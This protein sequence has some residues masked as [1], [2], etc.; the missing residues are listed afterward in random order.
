MKYLF[1]IRN[2]KTVKELLKGI[3]IT[4]ILAMLLLLVV[5]V[6]VC[7]ED[8]PKANAQVVLDE[9]NY[10]LIIKFLQ[11][12]FTTQ[13]GQSVDN[14]CSLV[15]IDRSDFPDTPIKNVKFLNHKDIDMDP[16]I[17]KEDTGRELNKIVVP[18]NL[19]PLTGP[20]SI[21]GDQII[22]EFNS[23]IPFKLSGIIQKK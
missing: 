5:Q 20:R 18:S 22:V 6:D 12:P 21:I 9:G 23:A 16:V 7:A 10:K 15:E 3:E 2:N 11:T 13:D 17:K 1:L 14:G 19:T 8:Y 4:S